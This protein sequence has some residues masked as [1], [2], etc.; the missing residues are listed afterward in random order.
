M[1]S[2]SYSSTCTNDDDM[3]MISLLHNDDD[4]NDDDDDHETIDEDDSEKETDAILQFNRRKETRKISSVRRCKLACRWS[5]VMIVTGICIWL[6]HSIRVGF[7][8]MHNNNNDLN[9]TLL[10]CDCYNMAAR[11][12]DRTIFRTHKFGTILLGDMFLP[13]RQKD[14]QYRIHTNPTPKNLDYQLPTT[15][16]YRHVLVTRNWFDAIVSGYLYHQAGYE[17]VMDYRG[18]ASAVFQHHSKYFNMEQHYHLA[19]WDKQLTY[20]SVSS[21]SSSLSIPPRHNRSFCEYLQDQPEEIGMAVLMDFALSRWYKGVVAYYE[22]A[23][24]RDQSTQQQRSL[25]LCFEDLVDPFQQ[26][27]FFYQ[28]VAFLF[29]G[30]N[31]SEWKLPGPIQASIQQQKVSR[32][33]KYEGGHATTHDTALRTRL[34]AL[35]ER[36]DRDLFGNVVATSSAV[37]GCGE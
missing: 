27:G 28:M 31:A 33:G 37:F 19:D 16:D 9:T 7:V 6:L 26:E 29:P 2:S 30:G 24:E 18:N 34:R 23:Q 3:E 35:A 22:K 14:A 13:N 36:L 25:F 21:T 1:D 20:L 12:C 8:S 5:I 32:T 10:S 4:N 15:L 17:C 11:C